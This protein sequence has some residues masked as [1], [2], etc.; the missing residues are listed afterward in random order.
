M[1]YSCIDIGSDTIKIVVGRVD[2][3]KVDI[4]AA[5]NTRMVGIKKGKIIDADLVEKSI[6]LANEEVEKV[7]GF[8]VNQAIINVPFDNVEV[9]A[10]NGECYPEE[11]ITGEDVIA[12][13]KSSV[14]TVDVDKEV[15]TVFP[16]HFVIDNEKKCLNPI[17]IKAYKL[18]SK[19][20]IATIPKENL[21][22]YLKVLKK[23]NIEVIDLSFNT[24][25]EFY[26]YKKDEFL[27]VCGAVVDI[28]YSKTEVAVFNKG[29]MIKGE[30][31]PLGSRL[32][33]N[34]ISYIYHLD[35]ETS[36]NLKETYAFAEGKYASMSNT[37]EYL[38]VDGEK[39]VISQ[40][41]I[42]QIVEARL[43][44]ILKSVKNSLNNL[45]NHEISYIIITGGVSNMPSFSDLITQVFPN[46]YSSY[47]DTI[48]VRNNI[49]TSSVGMLKY[50]YDKLKVRGI[51][52]TMYENVSEKVSNKKK[53]LHNKIIEEMKKYCEDN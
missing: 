11:E 20:L 10:Y 1:I 9:N 22:P 39:M 34:D 14:A 52:Y 7:L 12:C 28:G 53:E 36:R 27:D 47:L 32:V 51:T 43:L 37:V 26:N 2:N 13:F 21:F 17:G 29:L 6:N 44:E 19:I 42:S 4:L 25:N 5:I 35:K 48:G 23:C 3:S 38:T 49:Y 16:I 45:T 40:V 41:E 8:K 31:L 15:V 33:D 30:V 24:V 46:A 18:E 50:Y